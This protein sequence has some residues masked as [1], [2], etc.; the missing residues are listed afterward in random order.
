MATFINYGEADAT[1]Q[2]A[3]WL[4]RVIQLQQGP[5]AEEKFA[6]RFKALHTDV[7]YTRQYDFGPVFDLFLD[8]AEDLFSAIPESRA[9][10]KIKE[11]ESFFALVLSMLLMLEEAE[12]LDKATNRLC[13]IFS[14]SA[15][16]QPELRLRLLM[17]LYNAFP[18]TLDFRYRVFKYIID[19]AHTANLFD[20]VMPYLEY[21]D[22]WMADWTA[23]LTIDD[24]RTL[25]RDIA[26]Y[27]HALGK[28]VDSFQY[29]KRYHQLFQGAS[30]DAIKDTKVHESTVQLLKDAIQIPSVIQFDDI[31]SFDTVKAFGK[32]KEGSL[33]KLCEVFFSGT[34]SDLTDFHKKNAAVFKEHDLEIQDCMSKIKLLTLATLARNRAEMTLQEVAERLEESEEGVE[35]WVVRA[36]SEGIIDGRIDQLNHK[37][38]VKSAFQ[39]KFEKDEWAFL[40]GKLSAWIDNL[41]SVIKFIG[42]QKAS[43][44]TAA[45]AA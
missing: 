44:A 17:N 39:R 8:H 45:A 35:R 30:A 23:Y 7:E 1:V 32:T 21:L 9:E 13:E 19:F 34:V 40:D 10:E 41:E 16:Q 22:A 29:L 3:E 27:V 2:G 11:V 25:F 38:L 37:V 20:Q 12:Q 14:S 24:K 5:E 43:T 6:E 4:Q 26:R 28:R 15:K 33:V 42:D 31:L 36:I 18:P